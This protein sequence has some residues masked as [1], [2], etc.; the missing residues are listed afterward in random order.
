MARTKQEDRIAALEER[1][2]AQQEQIDDL[3]G[4]VGADEWV[5]FHEVVR[6]MEQKTPGNYQAL[7]EAESIESIGKALSY[8]RKLRR[9]LVSRKL[10]GG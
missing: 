6:W 10:G 9:E 8:S 3:Q 4:Q 7:C 1:V 5:S 2:E